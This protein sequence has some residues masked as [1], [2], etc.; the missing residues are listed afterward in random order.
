MNQQWLE[1]SQAL[2]PFYFCLWPLSW[3][4]VDGLFWHEQLGCAHHRDSS[5]ITSSAALLLFVSLWG[6]QWNSAMAPEAA[7]WRPG[8]RAGAG[9]E[10]GRKPSTNGKHTF[11]HRLNYP[12]H[13]SR[14]RWRASRRG[15]VARGMILK[16]ELGHAIILGCCEGDNQEPYKTNPCVKGKTERHEDKERNSSNT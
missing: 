10:Q 14:E 5:S 1:L 2:S 3:V 6:V 13:Y 11:L 12:F 9:G 16:Q 7:V 15:L 8:R 4:H